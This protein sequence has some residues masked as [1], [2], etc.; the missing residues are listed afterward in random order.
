[1]EW[2]G[3]AG[4]M[5]E[6]QL[7]VRG[8]KIDFLRLWRDL[9]KNAFSSSHALFTRH[10]HKVTNSLWNELY[11]T[12]CCRWRDGGGDDDS[13]RARRTNIF[14]PRCATCPPSTCT[15]ART[16]TYSHTLTCVCVCDV[17]E[18]CSARKGALENMG[19]NF[20]PSWLEGSRTTTHH[21][22]LRLPLFCPSI[23][24]TGLP[25]FGQRVRCCGVQDKVSSSETKLD[26]TEVGSNVQV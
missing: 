6:S 4:K 16:S 7:R 13:T 15:H 21:H 12:V 5:K 18:L 19:L 25:N 2:N 3:M 10:T 24:W 17:G 11:R 23:A 9:D 1:M 8:K 20:R 22:W 26:M 14:V